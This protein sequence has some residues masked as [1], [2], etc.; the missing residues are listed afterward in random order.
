MAYPFY[1]VGRVQAGGRFA[2][3]AEI[4]IGGA[5]TT[6]RDAAGAEQSGVVGGPQVGLGFDL[7]VAPRIA[8]TV[9]LQTLLA[10]PDE[11]VDSDAF[12]RTQFGTAGEGG[13]IEDVFGFDAISHLSLGV[14][15]YARSAYVAP[16][17]L[18]VSGPTRLEAGEQ[19]VYRATVLERATQPV[20]YRW[21]FGDGNVATGLE[22]SHAFDRPGSYVVRFSATGTSETATDSVVTRVEAALIAP[23]IQTLTASRDRSETN[24][25]IRFAVSAFGSEPLSYRWTMG[26]GRIAT[27]S[28][29]IHQ[30]EQEGTYSA[31][32]TVTNAAG[33]TSRTLTHIVV[34]PTDLC[35]DVVELASVFFAPNSSVLTDDA[36]R[37]LAD[38]ADVLRNCPALSVRVE[39]LTSPRERDAESLSLA[40]AEAVRAFYLEVGL[41]ASVL[42]TLGKSA[43]GTLTTRKDDGS[44]FR[45]VDSV[46]LR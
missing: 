5:A 24:Q 27:T 46:V 15:V 35:A 31:T 39:G 21:D 41:P 45:R 23:A 29:V 12:R 18:A 14:K 6:Y 17:I 16:H 11:Q 22:T 33:E 13:L 30:Y 34:R 9:G 19:G 36:R 44:A 20:E 3:Y 38:N 42:T 7:L 43:N 32:V 28:N 1:F 10:F 8:L 40:R 26:D 2:P 4:G 37:A 25:L